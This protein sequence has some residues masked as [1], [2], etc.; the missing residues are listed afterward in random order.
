MAKVLGTAAATILVGS[1]YSRLLS[2]AR[3]LN[4]AGYPLA[5]ATVTISKVCPAASAP[6]P[7]VT[8]TTDSNGI[9]MYDF[10]ADP[11]PIAFRRRKGTAW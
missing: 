5:N 9:Y 3:V 11:N 8:V 1:S 6:C 7:Y 2:A 4:N 10:Y